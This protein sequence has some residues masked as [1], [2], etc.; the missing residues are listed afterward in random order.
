MEYVSF[1]YNALLRPLPTET[2]LKREGF[3]RPTNS[4]SKLKTKSL[5]TENPPGLKYSRLQSNQ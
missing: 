5:Q 2:A 4:N 3:S 1:S